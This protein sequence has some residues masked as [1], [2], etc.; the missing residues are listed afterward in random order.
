MAYGDSDKTVP[1]HENGIALEKFYYEKG[2]DD[3]YG[4]IN[5][6]SELIDYDNKYQGVITSLL[7]RTVVAE[8]LDA[9]VQIAKQYAYKFKIV[10]LDGQVVNAGGSM[11]GGAKLQNAGI[12]S[13]ANEIEKLTEECKSLN[14]KLDEAK[15]DVA[16]QQE[17]YSSL[18]AEL[19]GCK[20]EIAF[21]AEE[22]IRV[23]GVLALKNGQL[24]TILAAKKEADDEKENLIKRKNEIEANAK[25][26]EKQLV[27]LQKTLQDVENDLASLTGDRESLQQKREEL[28]A[29]ASGIN[30]E[31]ATHEKEIEAKTEEVERLKGRSTSHKDRLSQLNDEIEEIVN[32]NKELT[33]L[34]D[35]L[36][37][38]AGKLRSQS[39]TSKTDTENLIK[40][41]DVKAYVIG[42]LI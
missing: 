41:R 42:P 7:G 24:E 12:L 15:K 9:A 28:T 5:L 13:R 3:C 37:E 33:K 8:D 14:E 18:N 35:V 11:T 2:L 16:A 38:D 10:T 29:K 22:K 25:N 1:Y 39:S 20:A 34:I 21:T 6:A 23:E 31:I 32:K 40:Q 36:K 17:S 4:Y 27:E 26:A 19:E 30:L